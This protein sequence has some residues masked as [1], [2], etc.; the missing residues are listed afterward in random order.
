M[1]CMIIYTYRVVTL[2]ELIE[3][4]PNTNANLN[5][6]CRVELVAGETNTLE[7]LLG[8]LALKHKEPCS[9]NHTSS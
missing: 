7:A 8:K 2:L 4:N 5:P 9:S 3:T 1:I 6:N